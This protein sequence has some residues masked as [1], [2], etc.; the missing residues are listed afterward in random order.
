MAQ[1]LATV[2]LGSKR[3]V[4][5]G[6]GQAAKFSCLQTASLYAPVVGPLAFAPD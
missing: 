6:H 4:A 1:T 5:A 2:W 3:G